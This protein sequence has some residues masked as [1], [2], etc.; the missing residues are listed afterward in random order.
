MSAQAIHYVTEGAGHKARVIEN[1][2]GSYSVQYE[3]ADGVW[4]YVTD[5]SDD[6]TGRLYFNTLDRARRAA[7]AYVRKI[8]PE[9]AQ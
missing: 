2:D 3:W 6:D 1:A 7:R 8:N 5:T 9:V 4:L